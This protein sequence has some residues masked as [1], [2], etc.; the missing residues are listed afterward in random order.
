MQ[1]TRSYRVSSPKAGH[2]RRNPS[3]APPM[4]HAD[5]VLRASASETTRVE[6][7]S[8]AVFAIP[9]D[10]QRRIMSVVVRTPDGKD[11]SISKGAPE[12]RRHDRESEVAV[13]RRELDPDSGL[14]AAAAS[15]LEHSARSSR[16]CR[17]R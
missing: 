14:H 11:R 3:A 6:T 2:R 16:R 13:T 8:D 5:H 12:A 15:A 7:F 17:S 9:F 1:P 4:H 10:F